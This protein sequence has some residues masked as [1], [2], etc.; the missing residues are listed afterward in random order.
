MG[1]RYSITKTVRQ[2]TWG[3]RVATGVG[4][5]KYTA[6]IDI[7]GKGRELKMFY[8]GLSQRCGFRS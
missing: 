8:R 5:P 3:P 6:E 4:Q 2:E 7:S 1:P